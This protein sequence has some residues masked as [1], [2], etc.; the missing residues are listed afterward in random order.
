MSD[1][2]MS[3]YGVQYE[4]STGKIRAG[5]LNKA[6]D[7]LVEKQDVSGSAIWAVAQWLEAHDEGF[8]YE[9]FKYVEG[10]EG[11]RLIV[12]KLEIGHA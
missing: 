12:E 2:A 9:I 7:I 8:P 3:K 5:R 10:G 6:G 1:P 4:P 11:Y